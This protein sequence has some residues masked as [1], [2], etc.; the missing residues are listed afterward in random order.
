V[1]RYVAD[2]HALIYPPAIVLAELYYLIESLANPS[3]LLRNMPACS[4]ADSS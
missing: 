4:R 2:I 1:R 3:T